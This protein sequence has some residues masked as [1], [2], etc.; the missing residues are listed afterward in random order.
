MGCRKLE[1]D[2]RSPAIQMKEPCNG[3]NL[4]IELKQTKVQ[5]CYFYM[6]M[7][8][9][10]FK[11]FFSCIS[12]DLVCSGRTHFSEA[13]RQIPGQETNTEVHANNLHRC[14]AKELGNVALP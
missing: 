8:N 3:V 6:N 2:I 9:I 11:L 10:S 14:C 1:T 7:D 12:S 5:T 13:K 4:F